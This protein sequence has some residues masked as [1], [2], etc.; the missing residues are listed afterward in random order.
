MGQP[1]TLFIRNLLK[2]P[3]FNKEKQNKG[4]VPACGGDRQ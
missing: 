3:N 2:K 1:L 4:F